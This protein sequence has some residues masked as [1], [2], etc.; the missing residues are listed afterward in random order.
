MSGAGGI[1]AVRM[2]VIRKSFGG[3]RALE[4]VDFAVRA[5]VAGAE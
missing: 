1:D 2:A 4:G 5:G 3:V